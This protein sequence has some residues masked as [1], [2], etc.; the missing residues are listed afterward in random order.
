MASNNSTPR[1]VELASQIST[2][3]AQLQEQLSAEGLA[4]PS[5]DED[6]PSKY[7]INATQL[8]DTLLDATAELHELL[9]DP[10]M[11]LFKFASVRTLFFLINT[12][13]VIDHYRSRTS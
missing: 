5:F 7:P 13:K 12:N 1:I 3:V 8:R 4:S 6:F 11:L 10:L 2:S 9:L